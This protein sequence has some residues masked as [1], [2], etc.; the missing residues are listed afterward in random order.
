MAITI[1]ETQEQARNARHVAG[2]KFRCAD[3]G[4][5]KDVQTTGG[6]GYGYDADNRM[7]CYACCGKRDRADLISK[8]R[9]VLYLNREPKGGGTLTNWPGTLTNWPGTLAIPCGV[10]KGRHNMAGVRYDVWFTLAGAQWHGVQYGNN[11]QLCHCRRL[12]SGEA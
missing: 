8:G 5:V 7:V 2:V 6:T 10:R 9:G 4:Q 11:T 1:L 12:K 3:C